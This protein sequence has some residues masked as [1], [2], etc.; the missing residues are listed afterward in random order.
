MNS[1]LELLE[2]VRRKHK[3]SYYGLQRVLRVSKQAISRYR[4]RHGFFDDEVAITVADELGLPRAHVLA[5]VAAERAKSERV[6]KAWQQAAAATAAVVLVVLGADQGA[7]L[8]EHMNV[9]T[10]SLVIMS[11]AALAILATL[12]LVRF[13]LTDKFP[14]PR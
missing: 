14:S 3:A 4:K 2:A 8:I 11:N 1:T 12:A 5:I 9:A 7:Q 13:C 6:K 10:P